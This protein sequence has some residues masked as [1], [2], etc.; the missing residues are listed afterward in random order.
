MNAT[1]HLRGKRTMKL[2]TVL[3]WQKCS[4]KGFASPMVTIQLAIAY[5][6]LRSLVFPSL[7]QGPA[8]TGAPLPGGT[9]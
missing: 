3:Y 6:F 2:R 4:D 1:T 9:A 8:D 7:K 5:I